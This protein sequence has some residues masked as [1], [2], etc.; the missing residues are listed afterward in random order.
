[1]PTSIA[2]L[3]LRLREFARERDWEEF[4]DPK[5]LVMLLAS[6]VGELVAEF[7]WL[8]PQGSRRVIEDPPAMERIAKEIGD[9]GI[10]LLAISDKLGIDLLAAIEAKIERN[11]TAYP[12]DASRGRAER[13]DTLAP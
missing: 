13:P 4:H 7:R 11:A 6:E 12:V 2:A 8:T 1:M 9:V 3:Q 5:N 10:A